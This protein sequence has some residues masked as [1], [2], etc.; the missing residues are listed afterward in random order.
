MNQTTK[1]KFVLEKFEAKLFDEFLENKKYLFLKEI[2]KSPDLQ[3]MNI[4]DY[5]DIEDPL[6]STILVRKTNVYIN[7]YNY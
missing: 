6:R 7:M 4:L 1:I 5:L 2:E 3:L